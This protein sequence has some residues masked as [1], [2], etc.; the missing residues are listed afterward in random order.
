MFDLLLV[1]AGVTN[2]PEGTV[3]QTPTGEFI[4][5]M[6]ANALS[7]LRVGANGAGIT[8]SGRRLVVLA[9]ASGFLLTSNTAVRRAPWED[10]C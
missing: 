7:P 6:V 8:V 1:N 2:Q 4:R 10:G 3:A 5:V 9:G